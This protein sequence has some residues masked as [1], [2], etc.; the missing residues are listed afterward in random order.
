MERF[1]LSGLNHWCRSSLVTV[2]IDGGPLA[3]IT[4]KGSRALDNRRSVDLGHLQA[5]V[6]D[7]LD[8]E[9]VHGPENG[10]D[11]SEPEGQGASFQMAAPGYD[12]LAAVL[13][14]AFNQAATGK[15]RER[16]AD[17]QP[18]E[19]QPAVRLCE[20]VG[21]GFA[22]G[23]ASKKILESQRLRPDAAVHELLGA[24]NYLASAVIHIEREAREGVAN[25]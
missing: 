25:D 11:G 18:F 5:L 14:N 6:S 13:C 17:G 16:H 8:H 9:S 10:G 23:Q 7:F 20:Q 19:Q 24:I 12:K 15:G 4:F 21:V 1:T 22:L 3:S 2:Q